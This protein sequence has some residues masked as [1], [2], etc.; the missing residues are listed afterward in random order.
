VSVI[1]VYITNPDK[2]TAK[3]IAKHLVQKRFCA[4][5]NIFPAESYYWWQE[6]IEKAK[7]WIVL[8]KTIDKNYEKI[9]KEV[10]KIHPY[11]IPC[12]LKISG[13]VNKDYLSWLER[14]VR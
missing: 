12:I 4:C 14:E 2:K 10:K 7:E 13:M 8:A 3:R 5:A 11:S 9:Q 1:L 6:E